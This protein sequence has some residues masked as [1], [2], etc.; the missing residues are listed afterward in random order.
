[1]QNIENNQN[2]L[3][4]EKKILANL[5]FQLKDFG[6]NPHHWNIKLKRNTKHIIIENRQEPTITYTG[7]PE[8]QFE[9]NG[10][11]VCWKNIWMN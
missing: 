5:K 4:I 1:M 9:R 7:R 3:N 11:F 6:M 8:I 10:I 2:L